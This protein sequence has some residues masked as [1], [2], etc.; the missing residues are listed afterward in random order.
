M[1]QAYANRSG[2]VGNWIIPVEKANLA[3]E[4]VD[5]L[6][7]IPDLKEKINGKAAVEGV[8]DVFHA[9]SF[10]GDANQDITIIVKSNTDK[11]EVDDS[12][13]QQDQTH[14]R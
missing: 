3:N 6:K 12:K 11:L 8:K 2:V 5:V 4:L 1:S 10:T 7:S 9:A 14:C 13:T